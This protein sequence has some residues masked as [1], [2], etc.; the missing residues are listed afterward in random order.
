MVIVTRHLKTIVRLERK[1]GVGGP[2]NGSHHGLRMSWDS[3]WSCC[4]TVIIREIEAV[5]VSIVSIAAQ[6]AEY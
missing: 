6:M 3:A 1:A 5:I 2:F 4:H